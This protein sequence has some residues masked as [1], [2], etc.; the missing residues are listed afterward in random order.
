MTITTTRP[1]RPGRARRSKPDAFAPRKR[2]AMVK[3]PSF[4]IELFDPPADALYSIETTARLAGVPRR[5]VLVYCKRRLISPVIGAA[6]R[7]YLFDR[8]GIRAL[9]RI[10]ALRPICGDDLAGIKIILELTTALERLHLRLCSLSKEGP[11][12]KAKSKS[13]QRR[14]KK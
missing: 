7:G 5:S 9:R 11:F 1:V 4:E 14:K 8:E 10:E 3:A 6:D 13:N 12:R 2:E